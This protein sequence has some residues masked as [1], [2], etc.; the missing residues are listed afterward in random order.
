MV[1]TL[2]K[3]VVPGVGAV[4]PG[5]LPKAKHWEEREPRRVCRNAG[6]AGRARHALPVLGIGVG[7]V[8]VLFRGAVFGM[9]PAETCACTLTRRVLC[10]PGGALFAAR[11][12]RGALRLK[13]A[14]RTFS[15]QRA[16]VR[17]KCP[18]ATGCARD[19]AVET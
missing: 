9:Q 13:E 12:G 3:H 7:I 5:N 16:I 19:G 18:L 14:A 1:V 4:R 2:G 10:V 11:A 17:R 15:A 6:T 8:E